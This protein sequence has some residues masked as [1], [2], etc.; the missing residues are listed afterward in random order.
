MQEGQ[1]GDSVM[2]GERVVLRRAT[3]PH[4]R[5]TGAIAHDVVR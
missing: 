2:Q 5:H 3:A 1:V 4:T